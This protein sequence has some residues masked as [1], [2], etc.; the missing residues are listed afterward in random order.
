MLRKVVGET[1]ALNPYL[2]RMRNSP[3]LDPRTGSEYQVVLTVSCPA[4][5]PRTRQISFRETIDPSWKLSHSSPLK[6][7]KEGRFAVVQVNNAKDGIAALQEAR[8]LLR[9]YLYSPRLDGQPSFNRT[10][11]NHAAVIETKTGWTYEEKSRRRMRLRRLRNI[12][13]F[14]EFGESLDSRIHNAQTYSELDRILYWIE[15][16]RQSE[17]LGALITLWT[18]M[19]FLCSIPGKQVLDA[20]VELAPIYQAREYPSSVLADFWRF[21]EHVIEHDG[22]ALGE[23]VKNRIDFKKLRKGSKCNLPR[24]FEVSIEDDATCPIKPLVSGRPILEY[25]WRRL[26]RLNP[27][28]KSK[29]SNHTYLW[30]DIDELE[31]RVRFDLRSCYRVRNTIVHDAAVDISQMEQ[32]TH[33]LHEYLATMLDRLILQFVRNPTL[34]LMNLHH[35]NQDSYNQWK[36]AIKNPASPLPLNEILDPPTVCLS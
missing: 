25:K 14:H 33:R 4:S 17:E 24:L 32:L 30:D 3:G 9:R 19:E 21:L 6:A 26:R 23:E 2:E 18:A 28:L 12:N 31:Q 20:V 8:R 13:R 11:S 34:S 29:A 27:S 5:I 22:L 16:S 10:I 35:I 7:Q 15:Q 1:P 36:D